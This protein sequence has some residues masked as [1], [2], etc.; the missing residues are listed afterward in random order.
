MKNVTSGFVDVDGGKIYYEMAGAGTPMVLSHAGFVDSGMWDSQWEP[1]SRAYQVIRYDMRGYGKSS[2]AQGPICR[3]DD[4]DSLLRHLNVERA[5]MV[6][7][8]MGG[9]I[10]LDLALEHPQMVA[11]LV[12]VSAVPSGFQPQGAPPA[13]LMEMIA[14]SQQGD[15]DRASELQIRIWVDGPFRQ[16]EQVNPDIR[17]QAAEMNRI[18]VLNDTWAKADRDPLRPLVPPAIQ[19][20]D[21]VAVPALIIDGAVDDPEILRAGDLLYQKIRG[22]QKVILPDA[23]HVPNMDKPADFN[24]AVLSFLSRSGLS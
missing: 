15:F 16:P 7:C 3:R 19:R 20:L 23:A 22:S 14:A 6:G 2:P 11:G 4:L 13:N 5:L 10:I 18:S 8:S 9:E 12:L 1:F 17:R 21:Q 24:R